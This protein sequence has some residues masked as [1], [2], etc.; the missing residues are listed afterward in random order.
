MLLRGSL[1]ERN[2]QQ[3]FRYRGTL[4]QVEGMKDVSAA[5]DN[6]ASLQLT[7]LL[8]QI[9]T[10]VENAGSPTGETETRTYYI[11]RKAAL[12]P[13]DPL[14]AIERAEPVE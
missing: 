6:T 2:G 13:T 8:D 1:V 3:I 14:L 7:G 9:T 4:V 10:T 5:V 11:V 12:K